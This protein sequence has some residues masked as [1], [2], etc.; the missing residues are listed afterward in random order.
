M[1]LRLFSLLIYRALQRCSAWDPLN[2]FE[3]F[4]DSLHAGHQA[5]NRPA[6][7]R[8]GDSLQELFGGFRYAPE[9][10]YALLI[11]RQFRGGHFEIIL[12]NRL[13]GVNIFV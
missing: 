3:H 6:V 5:V 4:L 13:Q 2:L 10:R 11:R 9:H 7:I 1:R 12:R 8:G